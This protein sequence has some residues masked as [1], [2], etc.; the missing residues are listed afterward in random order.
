M[1]GADAER[2]A[3][4]LFAAPVWEE[5]FDVLDREIRAR[6]FRARSV[7]P[8][9]SW[10][11]HRLTL[12]AGSL[13][14]AALADELGWSTRHLATRFQAEFGMRP[15]TFA[16]V[17]RF[18]RAVGAMSRRGGSTL[19]DVAA[20]A[21]YFDQAHFNRDVTAF[22]GLSP[23]MLLEAERAVLFDRAVSPADF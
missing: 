15:K 22:S 6:V 11:W 20:E 18:S 17:L 9:V 13:P 3:G 12:T 23:G 2:L 19:A 21:G 10:A 16:R 5:C 7:K 4:R 8:E 14:I 1:L